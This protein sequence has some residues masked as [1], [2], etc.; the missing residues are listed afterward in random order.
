VFYWA[1]S[2]RR[3][4]LI[5]QGGALTGLAFFCINM[6]KINLQY[7]D[8]I[9][10]EDK[11]YALAW[12][13]SRG[14]G[15]IQIS[16]KD[17]DILHTLKLLLGYKGTIRVYDKVAELNITNPRFRAALANAGCVLSKREDQILPIIPDDLIRHF[18]RGIFDSYGSISLSKGKYLNLSIVH[19]ETFATH[20]RQILSQLDIPTKH[21]YRYSHTTT[22][23]VMITK[24]VDAAKCLNYLY[25]DSNYYLTRKFHIWDRWCQKSV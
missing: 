17:V 25:S 4:F 13:W 3:R 8:I 14:T 21:Y 23:Q 1:A 5:D 7:F 9:D 11:A 6:Y 18:F 19:N 20:L 16:R 24:T 10:S 12:F 15:R 22:V 2:N